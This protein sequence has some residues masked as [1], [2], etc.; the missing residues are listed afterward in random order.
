MSRF[1]FVR[2][3]QVIDK[4][5]GQVI[6]LGLH[7]PACDSYVGDETKCP[8]GCQDIYKYNTTEA[9][10]IYDVETPS[11][12]FVFKSGFSFLVSPTEFKE[13]LENSDSFI[14]ERGITYT[15]ESFLKFC[16]GCEVPEEYK[17]D[18]EIPKLKEDD[19]LVTNTPSSESIRESYEDSR[20]R[21]R[22]LDQFLGTWTVTDPDKL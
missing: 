12:G 20:T 17:I 5:I 19:S 18:K 16:E 4:T 2:K 8:A 11:Y 6:N 7:C 22:N 1:F 14:D 21:A 10:P 9:E 13:I 3:G 15:K